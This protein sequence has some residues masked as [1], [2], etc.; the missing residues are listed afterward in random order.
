[1][2]EMTLVEQYR[3]QLQGF[4]DAIG[5][6]GMKNPYLGDCGEAVCWEMGSIASRINRVAVELGMRAFRS[7]LPCTLN[8]YPESPDGAGSSHNLWSDGWRYAWA[9]RKAA[10]RKP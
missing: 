4:R 8:P 7:G 3:I 2:H 1:L 5:T 10:K 6:P 9:E